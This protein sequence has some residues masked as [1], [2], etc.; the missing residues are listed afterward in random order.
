MYQAIK[1]VET[2][3][4]LN[5]KFAPVLEPLAEACYDHI[6]GCVSAVELQIP[7][8]KRLFVSKKV[9]RSARA[10]EEKNY[11]LE[12]PSSNHMPV[13]VRPKL[14]SNSTI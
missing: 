6:D 9:Q 1:G 11:S 3:K 7:R 13:T 5:P 10:S 2:R 12:T 14:Y 4:Y 8:S